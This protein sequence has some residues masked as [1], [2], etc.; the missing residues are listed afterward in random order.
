MPFEA[1]QTVGEQ[2]GV[3]DTEGREADATLVDCARRFIERQGLTGTDPE[4][5][6]IAAVEAPD[7]REALLA[8]REDV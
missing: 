2:G 7:L 5:L 4:S 8:L 1:L 3:F 6:A